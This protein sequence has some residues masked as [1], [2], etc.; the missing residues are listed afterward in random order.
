MKSI[1]NYLKESEHFQ[2]EHRDLQKVTCLG[3]IRLEHKSKQG[4]NHVG[5]E[6]NFSEFWI[7][8]LSGVG[9]FNFVD[10][11]CCYCT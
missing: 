10:V 2:L 9:L 7:S 5:R 11:Y 4:I 1:S 6:N 8:L 3:S